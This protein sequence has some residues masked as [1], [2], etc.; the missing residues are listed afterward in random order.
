MFL[1]TVNDRPRFTRT[2]CLRDIDEAHCVSSA[3]RIARKHTNISGCH[4]TYPEATGFNVNE[5]V[6][7]D[8]STLFASAR[9]LLKRIGLCNSTLKVEG[10]PLAVV[11]DRFAGP[12]LVQSLGVSTVNA[13]TD[14]TK[15][16]NTL[17]RNL[18]TCILAQVIQWC[19]RCLYK[20]HKS[21]Y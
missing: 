19:L 8:G 21:R 13:E 20:H 7:R 11:Q 3:E 6:W 10:S 4:E 15:A 18:S 12:P 17:E 5:I 14:A 9:S 16:A 1:R 2:T